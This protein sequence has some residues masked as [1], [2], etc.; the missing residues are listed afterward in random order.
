ML[1][2]KVKDEFLGYLVEWDDGVESWEDLRYLQTGAS[3]VDIAGIVA[4]CARI[5]RFMASD[6]EVLVDFFRTDPMRNLVHDQA[7]LDGLCGFRAVQNVLSYLGAPAIVNDHMI[8]KFCE[9][10]LVASQGL[11]DLIA[12][13][14]TANQL[15][16]FV[17][18][19]PQDAG[20]LTIGKNIYEGVGCGWLS[21]MLCIT[22]S[23]VTDTGVYIV[24]GKSKFVK[25]GHVIAVKRTTNSFRAIDS[26]G[27]TDLHQ[28]K[29]INEIAYVKQ[30]WWSPSV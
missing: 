28:Q 2:M 14:V 30:V 24:C 16:S 19:L 22:D 4:W 5:D 12:T 21:V 18:S 15:L 10:K 20:R 27:E 26:L 29:W 11:I 17:H 1:M 23:S 7:D 6:E 3:D 9:K 13:G 25:T 8:F